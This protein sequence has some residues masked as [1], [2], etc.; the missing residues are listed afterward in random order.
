MSKTLD[1]LSIAIALDLDIIET[2]G[3]LSDEDAETLQTRCRTQIAD[4]NARKV[5]YIP[6]VD[7]IDDGIFEGLVDLLGKRFGPSYGRQS[8]SQVDIEF[9]EAR[10][11]SA[12]RPTAPR[13]TLAVDPA[14][15]GAGPWGRR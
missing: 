7:Q 5:A 2:G 6:N 14:L 10:I 12:S 8:A 4:L 1:D 9:A 11:K 3:A 15:L 13:R